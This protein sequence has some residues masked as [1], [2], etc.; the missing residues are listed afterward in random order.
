MV[1]AV[2]VAFSR[3]YLYVHYPTDVL[4]SVILGS[5]FAIIGTLLVK[6][7]FEAWENRK[8]AA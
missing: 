1:I 7:G 5:C 2:L 6:K 3:L 8:K 4:A